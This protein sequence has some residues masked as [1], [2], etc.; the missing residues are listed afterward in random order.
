MI[1]F[2][3]DRLTDD[4][5]IQFCSQ[6][7]LVCRSCRRCRSRRWTELKRQAES[8][9][10]V[11][12]QLSGPAFDSSDYDSAATLIA[13][14]SIDGNGAVLDASKGT[15][16]TT[17]RFFLMEV[18]GAALSL[19]SL[20]L[21][22]GYVTFST[23]GGGAIYSSGGSIN[24]TNC[25]VIGNFAAGA[26]GGGA[27]VSGGPIFVTDSAFTHNRAHASG[28]GAIYAGGTVAIASSSFDGN[29]AGYNAG[30]IY[31]SASVVTAVD[32]NFT[33]NAAQ[34]GGAIGLYSYGNSAAVV[35][36]STV[37]MSLNAASSRGGAIFC[38]G[39]NELVLNHSTLASN[40]DTG[41]GGIIY[42]ESGGNVSV[43]CSPPL[44]ASYVVGEASFSDACLPPNPGGNQSVLRRRER[45]GT[46]EVFS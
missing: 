40:S 35:T 23:Y 17:R 19:R 44:N 4:G 37:A 39:G 14:I 18:A 32:S 21:A 26:S 24:I 36:L 1:K 38:G 8:A 41:G 6:R 25:T 20:T 13:S 34:T 16:S 29:T 46:I 15:S 3:G 27:I 22:N 9:S 45:R 43:H 12:I 33:S 2:A 7:L 28:G 42:V 10:A 31:A 30:A 11:S 5:C